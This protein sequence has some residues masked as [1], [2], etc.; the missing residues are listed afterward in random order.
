MH[1]ESE[2]HLEWQKLAAARRRFLASTQLPD[3]AAPF[4]FAG[5]VAARAMALKQNER[6]A[7]WTRWSVRAA[8]CAGLAAAIVALSRPSPEAPVSL[9]SAP[10]LDLPGLSSL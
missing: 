4:G 10:A 5:R 9:L 6:L 7:W 2:S 8:A 3:E 1:P